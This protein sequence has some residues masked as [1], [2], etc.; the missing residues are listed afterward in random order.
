MVDLAVSFKIQHVNGLL[1]DL[2]IL[3]CLFAWGEEG[4]RKRGRALIFRFTSQMNIGA[5]TGLGLKPQPRILPS[6]PMLMA[7]GKSNH[8][9]HYLLPL[10]VCI[11]RE[12][13]SMSCQSNPDILMWDM[14]ILTAMLNIHSKILNYRS[15][16]SRSEWAHDSISCKKVAGAVDGAGPETTH[17]IHAQSWLV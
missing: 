1:G 14:D 11:S 5:R 6:L 17:Q 2:F 10:R 12:M 7:G 13:K 15:R 4:E 3:K 16:F 8:F 9:S